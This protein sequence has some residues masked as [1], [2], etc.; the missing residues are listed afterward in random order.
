MIEV[1]A[2][3]KRRV[4]PPLWE[5]MRRSSARARWYLHPYAWASM[6]RLRA[7]KNRHRGARCFILGNGPSL[8]RM[9]LGPLRSELTFGLNR[10]YLLFPKLGFTTTYH[11]AIN[12]HVIEQCAA[13]IAAL[14]IPK[15]IA[16]EG[17]SA[18]P[19]DSRTVFLR[20][21]YKGLKFS[22]APWRHI[23]QGATVTYVAMQL[24]YYMG[25]RQVILIGV[26][27][28]FATQGR[29]NQLVVSQG[30]DPD[31]FSGRYFGAGFRWQLPDLEM[32][33]IA[34][35]LARER[36]YADGREVLDATVDGKLTVFPKVRYEDLVGT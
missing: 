35:E 8:R 32:S 25:F 18:L 33:E 36:F 24:A 31:H 30:E 11:V 14:P 15:F 16:W 7:L 1:K 4:P 10:I 2:A 17:R 28:H 20:S 22:T 27:H 13:E 12:P 21:C 29:P 23:W 3:L 6:V 34:Y 9:D 19:F 5:V 26:D